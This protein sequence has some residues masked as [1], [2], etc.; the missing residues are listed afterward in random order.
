MILFMVRTTKETPPERYLI[1]LRYSE[2][3]KDKITEG[4]VRFVSWNEADYQLSNGTTKEITHI[5]ELKLAVYDAAILD[6]DVCGVMI[7]QFQVQYGI[8]IREVWNNHAD[9]AYHIIGDVFARWAHPMI[10]NVVVSSGIRPQTSKDQYE[11][12]WDSFPAKYMTD[13]TKAVIKTLIDESLEFDPE[14]QEAS[15]AGLRRLEKSS[16]DQVRCCKDMTELAR[17]V[18]GEIT[19]YATRKLEKIYALE[20]C[21]STVFMNAQKQFIVEILKA[22]SNSQDRLN[23]YCLFVSASDNPIRCTDYI[24]FYFPPLYSERMNKESQWAAFAKLINICVDEYYWIPY[25]EPSDRAIQDIIEKCVVQFKKLPPVIRGAIIINDI[26]KFNRPPN[27][28]RYSF[29]IEEKDMMHWGI[30]D[31]PVPSFIP[32]LSKGK[33]DSILL[34]NWTRDEMHPVTAGYRKC[35]MPLWAGPSGHSAGLLDFYRGYLGKECFLFEK[36]PLPIGLVILPTMFTFWRLYYDKRICAV[37]TLAETFEGA[38]A[39]ANPFMRREYL[40]GQVNAEAETMHTPEIL[41]YKEVFDTIRLLTFKSAKILNHTGVMHPVRI[42]AQ[43]RATHYDTLPGEGGI[44]KIDALDGIIDGLRRRLTEQHY[45]VPRWA[46]PINGRP[47]DGSIAGSASSGGLRDLE[48]RSFR[49]LSVKV[50]GREDLLRQMVRRS[51][52]GSRN[53]VLSMADGGLRALYDKICACAA[54]GKSYQFT[55]DFPKL[56]ECYIDMHTSPFVSGICFSGIRE[57]SLTE[58]IF[59]YRA[60]IRTDASFWDCVK[61]IVPLADSAE[62]FCTVTETS[63]GL[64][65]TGEIAAESVYRVTDQLSLTVHRVSIES[66]LD[67]VS[68]FPSIGIAAEIGEQFDL[69]IV[70]S[71]DG[72]RLYIS[73]EYEEGRVLTVAAM[74]SLFGLDGV[75]QGS[76]LLPDEESVFGSLGLRSVSV[77][78]DTASEGITQIGF[79]VTAGKPWRIFGDK[80]TL[81]PYFE[82]NIEYPFDSRRRKTDYSVLGKWY[83]GST[84]FD[85]LYRSDK[86][87]YAGLAEDSTL[88]FADVAGLFAKD[89]SFPPVELTGMEFSADVVSGDYS[90]YL[91]AEH[92]LEFEVGKGKLG[93]EGLSLSLDFM[94]GKFGALKLGGSFALGGI[95]LALSGSYG[96]DTGLTFK[97]MAYSEAEYSLGE[98]IAQAARDFGQ[99][100]DRASLPDTLFSVNIRMLTASYESGKKAFHGYVDLENVLEVSRNFSIREMALEIS[101]E[102]GTSVA[103]QVI[104]RIHICG[105]EV[106][107]TVSKDLEG[108]ILSGEA[109]FSN[110]T[111]G[112]IAGAFGIATEHLPDFI[113]EFAI[114]HLGV[115]YNFTTKGFAL[116]LLTSAGKICAEINAGEQSEWRICYETDPKVS[117]D[118]LR[119]PLVGELV[120]KVAPGTTGLSVKDFALEASSTKGVVFRCMAFGSAC[121]LELCKPAPD[122]SV[123]RSNTADRSVRAAGNFTPETVKWFNL[124]KTFAILTVSKAGI[125]LDGSRVVLLLDASLAASPFTFSLAEAGVG[126]NI[127]RLSDVAFYLSG[128]GVAFDNGALAISGSFSRKRREGKEV[129]AGSLL[130]K[131]KAVTV[132]AVGEYSAGSLFAYMVL[133]ASIG[134]PPA[135]FV[136]GLALGFGYNRRLVL[137]SVEQVPEYPLIK[138][139]KK[140]FDAQTL[141]ELN[142]YITEENGQNFLTAGIRFTSFKIVDG[143]LLL[144]VSFGKKFQIGVLGIADISMPPNAPSNPVAKAQLAIRAEYDPSAGVFSAEA[145]LTSESYILSRDCRLTGG[146]AAFFWFEGSEH[147]GDFVITLG[148]YHPAFQKPAHYPDVPRLGLNWNVNSNINISGEIYFALTPS[149]VMAGGRLS[150]V[151][152]QGKLR[153]WFIAYADFIVSWKPF[154]YQAR[155]GVS[156]GA[157]YRVDVWFIHKTFSIELAA[158]LA[159]WGPEVQGRLHVSWFIISFTI[160]FSKGAD[161]SGETLDWDAFKESFLRDKGQNRMLRA[162]KGTPAGDTDI[163]AVTVAGVCGQAP[164]GTDIISPSG[165]GITLVSKIPEQGNVRPVNNVELKSTIVL[166]VEDEHKR[167]INDRFRQSSVVRNM[168]A[169]LWKSAPAPQDRLR[170]ENMVKNVRCGVSYELLSEVRTQE[171]FPGTRYISLDELYRNNTLAYEKCFQFIPDQCLH[172]SDEDSIRRFSQSADSEETRKRRQ[173]YLADNGITEQVSIARFAREAENWLSEELLIGI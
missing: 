156:L 147:S 81:Q 47:G 169:A 137:P 130:V 113:S 89:V 71:P 27:G 8:D 99:T 150:A 19:T 163:L 91:S 157:S 28:K 128:F 105:T 56:P 139:V 31:A 158:E 97:A 75:I 60:E 153:A 3:R 114:T 146:F 4:N 77:T 30:V 45:E 55:D 69:N 100:F 149:A 41:E 20:L 96:T 142:R 10:G 22:H 13:E 2:S 84:V 161:H 120:Q 162:N 148:G 121:T 166:T 1:P 58:E 5:D 95:T 92:V 160:S 14:S 116:H 18:I 61:G 76:E 118:M 125:G 29:Q 12:N 93:I 73:G 39:C 7:E 145:R 106:E 59:T 143:F 117:V 16:R 133:S 54:S 164:D 109:V 165:F 110:L 102:E 66:G 24:K 15:P 144:S 72:D 111:F 123:M 87:I 104:A 38:L 6:R 44:T 64:R 11:K 98:F 124:N 138:A 78:A 52:M 119:M 32:T 53:I 21:S 167:T 115:K 141:E 17:A 43:I 49:V 35:L 50:F 9:S 155:I 23:L 82:M 40:V 67:D 57:C 140:G 86:T 152:T 85:L 135:F 26:R 151:Y 70:V 132:T 88:R 173:R 79:T 103:F 159:L 108:F 94:D 131:C 107:L 48:I 134:G 170:E 90:L 33:S 34:R 129:Y 68:C 36:M 126:I 83:I 80:I 154:Y 172:L 168:P 74:L 62:V 37:H 65:F 127:S 136:T 46:Q 42:M 51:F 25:H 101:S 112:R 171:L 122:H 63:D